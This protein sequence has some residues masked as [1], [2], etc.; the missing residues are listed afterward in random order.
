MKDLEQ[1]R[2]EAELASLEPGVTRPIIVHHV[3]TSTNDD[4]RRAA[5]EGAP[6]GAVFLAEEQ[7]RGRGRSG[8]AWHSP[9]G[10]NLY[11]S[12]VLR[13][14]VEP[15]VLPPL[16][17]VLGLV[18]ARVVDEALG[19]D[20]EQAGI[21]WPNDVLVDGKK[22]SGLLVESSFRGGKIDAVVAGIGLNVHTASFPDELEAR[23]TSLQKLGA[24]QLDRSALA[25]RL[26]VGID[27]AIEPFVRE[28][29]RPFQA[30]LARRD[31]LFG[32]PVEV[33]DV[34]GVGAGIDASGNLLLRNEAG[35]VVRVGSG[36]V[37]AL[38]PFATLGAGVSATS[39]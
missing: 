11:L 16:A 6:H 31:V 9:P 39:G 29:V 30:E 20:V 5:A 23:A 37:T 27:R 10:E 28:G 38:G 13:P 1:G 7:T 3:T 35:A 33:A 17:L 24:R 21:K 14:R 4:A 25:A 8:H 26:L 34:R 15:E 18:V 12:V 36:S 19:S 32:V 22:V 2:I